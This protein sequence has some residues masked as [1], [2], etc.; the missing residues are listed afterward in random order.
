MP[1]PVL[2]IVSAAEYGCEVM[3]AGAL[4]EFLVESARGAREGLYT[5]HGLP[6]SR[7]GAAWIASFALRHRGE[8]VMC[9]PP[10]AVQRVVLP[11]LARLGPTPG[12]A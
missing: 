5:R 11:L 8:T 4:E 1:L 10:P 7:R 3:P 6:T 2:L 12:T 9:S